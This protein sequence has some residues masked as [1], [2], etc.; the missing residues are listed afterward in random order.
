MPLNHQTLDLDF[1]LLETIFSLKFQPVSSLSVNSLTWA[2]PWLL[3]SKPWSVC[4]EGICFGKGSRQIF[5]LA[6]GGLVGAGVVIFLRKVG[7]RVTTTW[8]GA[9]LGLVYHGQS[10]CFYNYLE[11]VSRCRHYFENFA[12]VWSELA[13]AWVSL[14]RQEV[15]L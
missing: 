3:L 13:S 7:L 5:Y 11:C 9:A 10:V 12:C 14:V 15:A 2:S 1:R 4:R 8:V 6:V